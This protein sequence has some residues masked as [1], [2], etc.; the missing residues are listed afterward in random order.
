M[1]AAIYIQ[2]KGMKIE[3]IPVPV[4]SEDEILVKIRAT[5]ICG[6]DLKIAK[7]GH[8]K[9]KDGQKIVLGHEFVGEITSVGRN[10]QGFK[11]GQRV[12]VAP[13][14]GCGRCPACIQGKSNYCPDYTAFGIDRDG[15]HSEYV[16]IPSKF[17]VQGNVIPLPDEVSD[18]E[19]CILEPFSCVLNG[20]RVSKIELG[21]TVLIFG[22]GPI[23][24]MHL[25][26]SKISGAAKII[27]ADINRQ[28]LEKALE[29]G[30]D[31]IIDSSSM[32]ECS[33]SV[34]KETGGRG[35]NVIITAC[36]VR[37]VQEKSVQLLAPFGR[38]C[39]FGGL[40]KGTDGIKFDSNAVHY[41]N[42][43][44]TG[45]TGGSVDDFI[46]SME[47]VRNRKVKLGSIV[48]DIFK[49]SEMEKAYA[50]MNAGPEGKIVLVE[51]AT[52]KKAVTE[53]RWY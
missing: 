27:V 9:L 37:E 41:R 33:K 53:S 51:E 8:R 7:N 30:A 16:V 17:I 29:A 2:G 47:L 48:S 34:M 12:G 25:M 38:V 4:N 15:A 10:V 22:A 50:K 35:A 18:I 31:K 1:L 23:G 3:E 24:M 49:L 5:S 26:L 40:P 52:V 20:V 6:T 11:K 42:L 32:D 36:P 44:V 45:S 39:L 46:R 13:N 14:A 28:R 19:G 43:T 21:D